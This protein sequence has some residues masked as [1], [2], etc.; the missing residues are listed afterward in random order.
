MCRDFIQMAA[1]FLR[2]RGN[3]FVFLLSFCAAT[4]VELFWLFAFF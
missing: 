2:S 3:A 1:I 4:V